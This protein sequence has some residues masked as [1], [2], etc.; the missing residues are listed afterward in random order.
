[1]IY[2]SISYALKWQVK[3]APHYMF[4]T[5][6]KLINTKTGKEIKKIVNGRCIGYCIQGKFYSLTALKDK[7]EKIKEK[8]CPF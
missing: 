1:M 2:N 8:E 5:C 4:T 3:F 7:I 6:K